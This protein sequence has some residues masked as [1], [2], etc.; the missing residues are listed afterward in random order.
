[1]GRVGRERNEGRDDGAGGDVVKGRIREI[2]LL[3]FF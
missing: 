3:F 1:M 2:S